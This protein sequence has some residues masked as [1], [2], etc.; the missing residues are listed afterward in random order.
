MLARNKA[1]SK[2]YACKLQLLSIPGRRGEHITMDL[3]DKLTKSKRGHDSTLV[4]VYRL[5]KMVHLVP[6]VE[7]LSATGFARL[8]R[9]WIIRL[10][11]MP[12]SVLSDRGPQFNNL[13]W[14][15]VNKLT[16]MRRK[17]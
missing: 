10:H 3:I 4:F 5:S 15:Q 6:T 14:E 17:L 13:F 12:D 1:S 2:A 9:D 16:G 11:G 7:A 8:F